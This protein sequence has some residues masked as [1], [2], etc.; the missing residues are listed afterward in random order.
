MDVQ[1]VRTLKS[2]F[3]NGRYLGHRWVSIFV[4]PDSNEELEKRLLSR[5]SEGK[6]SFRQ[7]MSSA[8][9]ERRCVSLFNYCI[10]SRTPQEDW[11]VL[12]DIYRREKEK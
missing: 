10:H 8:A 11:A 12:Q 9:H 3:E 5:G 4:A 1:G 7:R 2:V 6:E